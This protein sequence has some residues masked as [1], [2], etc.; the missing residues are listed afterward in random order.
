MVQKL[1][2]FTHVECK[3]KVTKKLTKPH[4]YRQ[5]NCGYQRRKGGWRVKRVKGQIYGN[6]RKR[7][8]WQ[9][10]QNRLYNVEL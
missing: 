4:R 7:D 1:Y 8:F 2:D 5:Q 3:T 6:G 9:E 10:V